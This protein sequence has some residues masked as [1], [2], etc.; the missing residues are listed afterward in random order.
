MA[1]FLGLLGG[2]EGAV[3]DDLT[4]RGSSEAEDFAPVASATASPTFVLE[5]AGDDCRIFRRVGEDRALGVAAI[6]PRYLGDGERI[7]LVGR[8]CFRESEDPA[9]AVPVRCPAELVGR[10]TDEAR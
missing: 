2:C 3:R 8:A 7:R 9:R 10:A 6:C 1:L 5:R 4:P